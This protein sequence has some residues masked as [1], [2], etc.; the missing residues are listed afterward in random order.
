[1][2]LANIYGLAPL[3]TPDVPGLDINAN[4]SPKIIGVSIFLM[5]L[6]TTFVVLR[7]VARHLSKAG[8]WW[9]DWLILAAMFLS[10]GCDISMLTS[11][12]NGFGR[13]MGSLGSFEDRI[14]AAQLWLKAL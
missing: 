11:V 4:N 13:H 14:I 5:V 1:M 2:A 7:F 8:L 12:P 3:T 9:D 6:A 10:W